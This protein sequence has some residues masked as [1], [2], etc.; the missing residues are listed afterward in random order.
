MTEGLI[1]EK[2]DKFKD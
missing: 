1:C 2:G